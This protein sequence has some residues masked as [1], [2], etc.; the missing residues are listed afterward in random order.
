MSTVYF[1]NIYNVR[2]P[3]AHLLLN[4]IAITVP[5]NTV[6]C[7]NVLD[8][9]SSLPRYIDILQDEYFFL[10]T[11]AMITEAALDGTPAGNLDDSYG[12]TLNKSAWNIKYGM[13]YL[14]YM[15]QKYMRELVLCTKVSSIRVCLTTQ[16]PAMFVPIETDFT[17]SHVRDFCKRSFPAAF[18]DDDGDEISY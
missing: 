8:I 4:P 16:P 15:T 11:D 18:I 9:K 7:F 6:P 13:W 1:V 14:K 3:S 2:D 12:R 10:A 17:F 5:T